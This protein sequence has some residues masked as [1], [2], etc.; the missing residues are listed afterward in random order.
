MGEIKKLNP[1]VKDVIGEI[2]NKLTI[3]ENLPSKK[4]GGTYYKMVKVLCECGNE[5]EIGYKSIKKGKIKSCGCLNTSKIVDIEKENVYNHWTIISEVEPYTSSDG[6]K[7]R[8]VL[9]KC[10][11]GVEKDLMLSSLRT[12][13]S[14]SCGCMIEHKTGYHNVSVDSPIPEMSLEQ[15]NQRELHNWKIIEQVSA[16][17]NENREIIRTVRAQCKCGYI[18]E[19]VL[20]NVSQ[21]KQCTKCAYEEKRN[22]V[23]EEDRALRNRISGVYGGMKDRCNNPNSKDYKNYGGRGIRIEES[24]DTLDKFCEWMVSEGYTIDCKLQIDRENNDGNYS[25][26][27][28]RLLSH[29]ENNRNMRRNVMSWDIVNEIRFGKYENTSNEKLAKIFNCDIKT[30]ASVRNYKTWFTF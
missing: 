5:K 2:Y 12:G 4:L 13:S 26:D 14:K 21:S 22:K 3:I 16:K 7:M 30:I 6:S 10:V 18:K 28:C 24:F 20:D 15:M 17:R 29:A 11:C 1:R 27:N 9:A 25:V 19:S 8:K 23:S